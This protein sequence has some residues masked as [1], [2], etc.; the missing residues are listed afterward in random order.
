M[1]R[2]GPISQE[3]NLEQN[4]PFAQINFY[5]VRY[6]HTVENRLETLYRF[7]IN[8]LSWKRASSLLRS[9]QRR[10]SVRNIIH[11][12]LAYITLMILIGHFMSLLYVRLLFL[13][14]HRVFYSLRSSV[15]TTSP[16]P[17]PLSSC[18]RLITV[19]IESGIFKVRRSDV[20]RIFVTHIFK[21]CCPHVQSDL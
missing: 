21:Y 9:G 2:F 11:E 10:T 12:L 3:P 4:D 18:I 5:Y 1:V 16:W 8:S 6:K 15:S 20:L 13:Q 19:Q 7:I 17:V 14:T